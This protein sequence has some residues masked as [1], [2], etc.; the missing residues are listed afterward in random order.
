MEREEEKNLERVDQ[1]RSSI[2]PFAGIR[3]AQRKSVPTGTPE[4]P[5]LGRIKV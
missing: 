3:G 1:Q 4:R 5:R 2:G